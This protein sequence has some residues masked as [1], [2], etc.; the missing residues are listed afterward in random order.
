MG[1]F[2]PLQQVHT[3]IGSKS[4][5]T[6]TPVT[7]TAS[8]ETS[9]TNLKTIKTAGFVKMNLD[10]LYT[11]GAAETSN[12]L[13]IKV[14]GSPDGVNFYRLPTDTTSGGTSTLAAREWTF[15][16][17]N[18]DV[19]TISIGLDIYYKWTRVSVKEGGVSS[20]FGTV[21]CDATLCGK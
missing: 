6:R 20:A 9:G 15:T 4:G 3:L 7:L 13:D 5:T 10:F 17:V 12:T 11:M 16:G 14:E 1:N 8:Y 18:A 19:A 21:F 2:Y